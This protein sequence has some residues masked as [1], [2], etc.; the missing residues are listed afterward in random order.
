MKPA[1]WP[2]LGLRPSTTPRPRSAS[3]PS[4]RA[5]PN[6]STAAQL[7]PRPRK[8]GGPA[9]APGPAPQPTPAPNPVG[10][11]AADR[12][13]PPIIPHLAPPLLY[14]S[15]T[16]PC[17]GDATRALLLTGRVRN[18]R[19]QGTRNHSRTPNPSLAIADALHVSRLCP[20][21]PPRAMIG[22]GYKSQ[23]PEP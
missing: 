17:H 3:Q 4:Y 14:F 12:R 10:G 1:F 7:C 18:G 2:K 22:M 20:R 23:F 6:P 13:P 16:P 8:A 15:P 19:H 11:R 21:R 9:A 5:W